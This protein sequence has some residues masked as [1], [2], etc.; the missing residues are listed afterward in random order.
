[1]Q[2]S[3]KDMKPVICKTLDLVSYTNH[4]IFESAYD[5][6]TSPCRRAAALPFSQQLAH[7]RSR[8]KWLMDALVSIVGAPYN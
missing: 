2:H 4:Y 5:D 7:E 8:L 6:E 1:M 3:E